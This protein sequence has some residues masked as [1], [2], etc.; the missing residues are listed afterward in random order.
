MKDPS[1]SLATAT[2]HLRGQRKKIVNKLCVLLCIHFKCWLFYF[3][4]FVYAGISHTFKLLFL[5]REKWGNESI[6]L[7][8]VPVN[9]LLLCVYSLTLPFSPS[10]PLAVNNAYTP[11]YSCAL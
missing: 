7:D 5:L 10:V 11:L 1:P 9:N 8:Y 4:S 2:V 3:L 6:N